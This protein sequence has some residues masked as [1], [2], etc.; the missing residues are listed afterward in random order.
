MCYG[1]PCVSPLYFQ[2]FAARWSLSTSSWRSAYWHGDARLPEK[3][4]GRLSR[5]LHLIRSLFR[6]IPG[7]R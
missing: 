1:T 5:V 7:T 3:N 4:C 6:S 2:P